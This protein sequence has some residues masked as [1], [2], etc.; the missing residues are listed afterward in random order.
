MEQAFSESNDG[1]SQFFR[2][3]FLPAVANHLGERRLLLLFDEFDVLS[4]DQQASPDAASFTLF[5]YFQELILHEHQLVF[6]FVVGRRIEEL[7]TSFHSIFKQAKYQ[8][9]GLLTPTEARELITQPTAG[10]LDYADGAI[11]TIL[12]LTARHPYLTQLM[13]FEVFNHA[14]AKNSHAV[15]AEQ[16]QACIDSA[17]ESG[18]GALNWFWDGLPR[19]ERFIMSA[20]AHVANEDGIASKDDIRQVL[21]RYRIILTGL[22]LK[23]APDRLVAWDILKRHGP[24]DYRFM[25][26]LVRIW[27]RKQ[28]PLDSVRRDVDYISRRAVR[29]FENAREAHEQGD[30][31]YAR[32]EYRR[33]L[34]VNPNHS[35]AQLGLAQ[36][37]YENRRLGS[38]HRG[39]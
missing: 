25:I 37:E 9:I 33:A 17:L 12:T 10:V 16:V 20:I 8:R 1:A 35:G 32:E 19:A 28:H 21:E 23:D 11:E 34:Q 39:F 18:H 29:L 6:I 4:D 24:D 38:G 2:E 22:E 7:T 13:C 30:L 26:E 3:T 36:V 5:P 27:I 31:A 14:K 15:T